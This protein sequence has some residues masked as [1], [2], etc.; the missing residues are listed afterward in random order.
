MDPARQHIIDLLEQ[1][2]GLNV[3]SLSS[4]TFERAIARRMEAQGLDD[5]NAYALL[6]AGSDDEMDRLTEEVVIPETW[7]FRHQEPF[8][9]LVDLAR[10]AAKR[11]RLPFRVLSLPCSTGEEPYSVVM[12]LLLAGILPDHFEVQGID[13]SEQALEIAR[14]AIYR[15]NAFRS[16]NLAFREVFFRT[17]EAGEYILRDIVR[18]RVRFQRG[19]IVDADF[20][21]TLGL[22]DV[23]FCRNILIYLSRE[24]QQ[25]VLVNLYHLLVPGGTLFTGHAEANLFLGSPFIRSARAG[26][27][28][29]CR[30]GPGQD[31]G[32]GAAAPLQAASRT[33][34]AVARQPGQ[35]SRQHWPSPWPGSSPPETGQ[36]EDPFDRVLHLADTGRLAEAAASCEH[37]LKKD[38]P[39]ARW[40]YLLGLIRDSQ[41]QAEEAVRLL[42]KALYLDPRHQESLVMLALLAEQAGE[43]DRARN[44]R[45]RARRI[46]ERG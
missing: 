40:Y 44:Y 6:L 29:F 9:L 37:H 39:S 3:E 45:R 10:T 8:D 15:D 26:S 28:A 17:N 2:I 18:S 5:T 14:Q 38:G 23:I 7:F 21:G 1:R 11:Q 31:R 20:I 16:R 36:E 30:P 42:R 25:K 32:T 13:I 33:L 19:N 41:G 34:P 22:F 46:L 27:F 24:A 43:H 12:A 35:T 4:S